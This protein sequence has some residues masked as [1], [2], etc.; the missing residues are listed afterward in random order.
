MGLDAR[1]HQESQLRLLVEMH[2]DYRENFY[3][4]FQREML[5]S[6]DGYK[7]IYTG[8]A[9]KSRCV[10]EMGVRLNLSMVYIGRGGGIRTPDPLLPRQRTLRC[11]KLLDHYLSTQFLC[12]YTAEVCARKLEFSSNLGSEKG[13][14]LSLIDQQNDAWQDS[15]L[16]VYGYRTPKSFMGTMPAPK[17]NGPNPPTPPKVF[18]SVE[19][20]TP[21]EEGGPIARIGFNYQDEIAVGYLLACWKALRF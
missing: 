12:L 11:Q 21:S 17:T 20:A 1:I 7:I 19:D 14:E 3:E 10:G 15:I 18:S 13:A 6:S 8:V 4:E 9:R 5:G 2:G 16:I